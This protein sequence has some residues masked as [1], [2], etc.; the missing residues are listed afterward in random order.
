MGVEPTTCRLLHLPHL[1]VSSSFSLRLPF[2]F[3]TVF[4]SNCSH[5]VPTFLRREFPPEVNPMTRAVQVAIM[6]DQGQKDNELYLARV[7]GHRSW[8]LVG[9]ERAEQPSS[10]QKG[11]MGSYA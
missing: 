3:S 6:P 5:V 2:S 10:P 11:L 7:L 1:A 9:I 4:G 8:N